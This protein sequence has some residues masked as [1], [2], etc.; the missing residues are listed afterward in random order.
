MEGHSIHPDQLSNSQAIEHLKGALAEGKGWMQAL[1]E[2]MALWTLPEEVFRERPHKYLLDGE[3]FDWLLLA[4]RLLSEVDGLVPE[5]E[6]S[7]LLLSGDVS[8]S[9]SEEE[10][11]RLL[12]PEKH[13]AYLNYWYGVVVEEAILQCVEEE[14]WKRLR[15]G[16]L[17]GFSGVTDQAY[18]HIYGLAQEELLR[19]FRQEKGYPQAPTMTLTEAKEFTYWLFKY[20]MKHCE[21][22]RVASDTR[23]GILFLERVR[24]RGRRG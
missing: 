20:R 8:R 4:E 15:S 5:E 18:R 19:K 13:S 2:S 11:K 12:G 7:H 21:G 14:E 6:K 1:L 17:R 24:A 3:A 22:A 9:V 23:K 10:F 16:G